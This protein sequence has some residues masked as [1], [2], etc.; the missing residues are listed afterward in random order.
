MVAFNVSFLQ[1]LLGLDKAAREEALQLIR[2]AGELRATFEI[3]DSY[4]LAGNPQGKLFLLNDSDGVLSFEVSGGSNLRSSWEGLE[5]G[6]RFILRNKHAGVQA[7]CYSFK[8]R[9]LA[10][11]RQGGQP[12]VLLQQP[13]R[14]DEV[15]QRRSLRI[16]VQGA[17]MPHLKAWKVTCDEDNIDIKLG[18]L[19]TPLLQLNPER[20]GDVMLHN[21]SAG[22]MRLSCSARCNRLA[23]EYL[24]AEK[25]LLFWFMLQQKNKENALKFLIF[26]RVARCQHVQHGRID[27]GIHFLKLGGK[28]QNGQ[29]VWRNCAEKGVQGLAHWVH[30]RV[31]ESIRT[32]AA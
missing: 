27:L 13:R 14:V 12:V 24:D 19:G 1:K 23:R 22:G 11:K 30:E 32:G 31:K 5:A 28:D 15:V 8:T 20:P 4:P 9:V 6:V 26:S 2:E 17:N 10:L 16:S 25:R 18:N 7:K 3:F 29:I 21:I